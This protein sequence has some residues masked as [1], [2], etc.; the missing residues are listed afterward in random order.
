[1]SEHHDHTTKPM[2]QAARASADVF[3]KANEAARDSARSG[4]ET[5]TQ[6]FQRLT[7][8]FTQV[9][10]FSGPQSEELT[11]RSSE[12][13]QAV[14]EA[15]TV[16][17]KGAQELS[18][19]WLNIAQDRHAKNI[20]GIKRLAGCRSVQDLIAVQSDLLRDGVQE[21]ISTNKRF[22]E[23]SVRLANEAAQP[24][25]NRAGASRAA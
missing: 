13:V 15:S 6:G 23:F 2:E 18:R 5:A 20:D 21:L 9:L 25:Q 12:N 7:D 4:L 11:R 16:I 17:T 10:G 22:A 14:T 3:R 19:E 24:F 8:Q 1:M